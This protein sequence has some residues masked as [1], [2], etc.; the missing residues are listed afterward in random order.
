MIKL[1]VAVGFLAVQVYIY[2]YF[3]TEEVH[4]PRQSFAAFPTQLG[5]W[6]CPRKD[7]MTPDIL[8]NLGVTDYLICDFEREE[9]AARVGVYVGYHESQV[10]KEGGGAGG[11]QIHPPSHCLPGSGWDIIASS[12][13]RV[14]LPGLPAGGADVNRLVIA[15]GDA[16]QLVYYWYQ[17][18]GRVI[19]DDWMKIVWLFWDRARTQRTDG[20][21]VRFTIPMARDDEESAERLFRDLAPHI[22]TQ[23]PSYSPG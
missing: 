15:K 4:P 21:L 1:A 16:R 3:A 7:Q 11:G 22:T 19:A 10:R 18:R 2:N 9:P 14:E 20:S 8:E 6:R 17:E 5:D 12:K 23:L 13:R